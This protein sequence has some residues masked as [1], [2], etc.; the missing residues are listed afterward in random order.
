MEDETKVVET[1]TEVTQPVE[2]TEQTETQKENPNKSLRKQLIE[3]NKRI[4]E[5]ESVGKQE[6]TSKVDTET[7]K[8]LEELSDS[9]ETAKLI[10]EL[11][12]NMTKKEVKAFIEEQ[13]NLK[14]KSAKEEHLRE[15]E[16]QLTIDDVLE[17]YEAQGIKI[18]EKELRKA[19]IEEYGDGDD[20]V[21]VGEKE[22]KLVAKLLAKEKEA[23]FVRQGKEKQEIASKVDKIAQVKETGPKVIFDPRTGKLTYK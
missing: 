19:I 11:V 23:D 5:L 3:A 9:P 17:T 8:K 1:K 7:F 6:T 21:E 20:N 10:A 18:T 14:T 2:T 4:Q 13:E 22:I 16:A 12:E 15:M